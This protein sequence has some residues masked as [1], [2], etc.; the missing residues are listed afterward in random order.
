MCI[1]FQY[2]IYSKKINKYFSK[3]YSWTENLGSAK[4]FLTEEKALKKL[5]T[6]PIELDSIIKQTKV[7]ILETI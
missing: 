6:L 7:E 3:H 2:V 1:V 4:L 5:N